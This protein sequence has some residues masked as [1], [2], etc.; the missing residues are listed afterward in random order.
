MGNSILGP[1]GIRRSSPFNSFNSRA[2]HSKDRSV[3]RS[4]KVS[5]LQR[6]ESQ[7]KYTSTVKDPQ[8]DSI[9]NGEPEV[10]AEA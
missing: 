9:C 3:G 2:D 4:E 7:T 8:S 10:E 6:I 5:H 1:P